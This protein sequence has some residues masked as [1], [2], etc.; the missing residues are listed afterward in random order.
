MAQRPSEAKP[1]ANLCLRR[2]ATVKRPMAPVLASPARAAPLL[3]G[4]VLPPMSSMPT[5]AVAVPLPMPDGVPALPLHDSPPEG[6]SGIAERRIWSAEEDVQIAALVAEHGT[7]SWSIIAAK[8]PGRTGKQCRER[9]HNRTPLHARDLRPKPK[10]PALC[11]TTRLSHSFSL[12]SAAHRP[13]PGHQQGRVDDRRGQE[14]FRGS[15]DDGQ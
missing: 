10:R 1:T 12:A 11:C 15:C 14:A 13:R 3:A 6:P 5:A 8:L 2:K 9:W 4:R 7:R